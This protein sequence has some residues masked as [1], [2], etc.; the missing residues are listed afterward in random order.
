MTTY[1]AY[2]VT[3]NRTYGIPY[4]DRFDQGFNDRYDTALGIVLTEAGYDALADVD[5]EVD[6]HGNPA[7]LE[8]PCTH[9]EEAR[10]LVDELAD[11]DEQVWFCGVCG[12]ETGAGGWAA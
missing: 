9:P 1:S 10:E 3:Y 12:L 11:D 6:E 2:D 5:A 7:V 8:L 4:V